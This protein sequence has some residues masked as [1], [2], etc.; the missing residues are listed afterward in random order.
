MAPG[1]DRPIALIGIMGAG[2]STVAYRLGERF[3]VAV[4]DLD[5]MLVAEEGRSIA[6]LFEREGEPAFRRRER[7]ML[8]RTLHAGA[9]VLACG[10]GVVLDPAS[11]A[12][13]Q[14]SCRVVWLEVSPAA[15]AR[16]VGDTQALRP[17]LRGGA[18]EQRLETLLAERAP[19]YAEI[20]ELRILTDDRTPD[21]VAD[22]VADALAR[23]A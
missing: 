6:E 15:A 9:R 20:A 8:E 12:L 5:A 3:A 21:Q 2:K 10:G 19:L 1:L 13:L 11:R 17:L 18:P 22:A 4:A 14:R 7:E 23:V 16:R